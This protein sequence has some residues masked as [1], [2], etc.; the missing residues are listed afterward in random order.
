MLT[1]AVLDSNNAVVNIINASSLDIA[2]STTA[3]KCIAINNMTTPYVGDIWDNDHFIY[4]NGIDPD[5]EIILPDE[6]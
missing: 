1:Y 6:A 4:T 5:Q 3:S 2:Q